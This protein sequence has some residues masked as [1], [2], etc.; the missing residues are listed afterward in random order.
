MPKLLESAVKHI[1]AKGYKPAAARAIAASALQKAGE[2]RGG[3]LT[4]KGK[5]Q[6]ALG[7]KGRAKIRAEKGKKR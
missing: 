1:E 4:K 7:P 2:L 6:E 5:K 3:K